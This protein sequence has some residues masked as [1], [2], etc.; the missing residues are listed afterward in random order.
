M[1]LA[2]RGNKRAEQIDLADADRVKPRD[3]LL[4]RIGNSH[5]AEEL[6][7]QLSAIAAGRDGG[8]KSATARGQ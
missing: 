3:G 4:A 7:G 2:E 6:C 5:A 8:A 1:P